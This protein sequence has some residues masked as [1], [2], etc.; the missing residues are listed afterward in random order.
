MAC[1]LL[2]NAHTVCMKVPGHCLDSR[3]LSGG[4]RLETHTSLL[5]AMFFLSQGAPKPLHEGQVFSDL[6]FELRNRDATAHMFLQKFVVTLFDL[7]PFCLRPLFKLS[8][9]RV[10]LLSGLVAFSTGLMEEFDQASPLVV[11]QRIARCDLHRMKRF[12]A[13]G[14]LPF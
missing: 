9:L 8:S 14:R 5:R 13:F 4:R 2:S 11:E 3:G 1:L 10:S 6:C 7:N 12:L